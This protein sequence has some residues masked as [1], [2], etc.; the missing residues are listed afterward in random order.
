LTPADVADRLALSPVTVTHMLRAGTLPGQKVGHLWRVRAADLDAYI[1]AGSEA[2]DAERRERQRKARAKRRAVEALAAEPPAADRE[3]DDAAEL[4]E[5]EPTE[6]ERVRW[7][8]L[9][10]SE[11]DN[12]FTPE[13]RAWLATQGDAAPA[14]GADLDDDD[15]AGGTS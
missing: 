7:A 11:D 1:V 10:M 15:D 8:T 14:A 12:P 13:Y 5:R 6:A 2:G 3:P 9:G 4:A